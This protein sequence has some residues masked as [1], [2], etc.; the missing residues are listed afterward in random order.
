MNTPQR[1]HLRRIKAGSLFKLIFVATA[2][3]FVP[4]VKGLL[5]AVLL[6]PLFTV[7]FSLFAWFVACMGIRSWGHFRAIRLDYVPAEEGTDQPPRR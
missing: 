7:L 5:A 1:I 4:G 3:V 6:T 2:T